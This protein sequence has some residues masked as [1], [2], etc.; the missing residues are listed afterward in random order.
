MKH[1]R[2]Q[3]VS[4]LMATPHFIFR[5]LIFWINARGFSATSL[6]QKA[7]TEEE[8]TSKSTGR[9]KMEREQICTSCSKVVDPPLGLRHHAVAVEKA[10]GVPSQ[11]FDDRCADGEIRNEMT[12]HAIDVQPVGATFDH[13]ATICAQIAE[14]RAQNRRANDG[15]HQIVSIT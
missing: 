11:R 1:F 13:F 10:G 15:F 9:L 12:V 4:G 7:E 2:N 8:T 6:Q 14:I 3:P 5:N